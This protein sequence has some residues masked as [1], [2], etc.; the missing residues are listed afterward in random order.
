MSVTKLLSLCKFLASTKFGCTVAMCLPALVVARSSTPTTASTDTISLYVASLTTRRCG[1]RNTIEE[2]ILNLNVWGEE[3]R[4]RMVL[5]SARKREDILYPLKWK[6][7]VLVLN[8]FV[9]AMFF[10]ALALWADAFYKSECPSVCLCVCLSVFS[11]LRYRLTVFSTPLPEVGCQ[12]FLDILNPWG[13]VMERSGLT[14]EHFC[15]KVV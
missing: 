4:K 5:V 11:L 13:K 12:I 7:I 15:L 14:F 9:C 3:E 10:K 1:A 8:T 2:I 6:Y